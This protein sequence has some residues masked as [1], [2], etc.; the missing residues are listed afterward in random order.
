MRHAYSFLLRNLLLSLLA[1]SVLARSGSGS[2]SVRKTLDA[3]YYRL[4]EA[5]QQNEPAGSKQLLKVLEDIL[6]PG[7]L[8]TQMLSDVKANIAAGGDKGLKKTLSLRLRIQHL[9]VNGP[10]A[11]VVVE[12]TGI[13][14]RT[15]N[16]GLYGPVG[17]E[18]RIGGS[19]FFRDTWKNMG[20]QWKLTK[21]ED[22]KGT[23]LV[24]GKVW[25]PRQEPHKQ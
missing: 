25:K 3:A 24:D 16:E 23:L 8:R 13:A 12:Q 11:V 1:V 17:K 9:K 20:G 21:T 7:E 6:A 5:M 18:H 2:P 15:D 14:I 22:L 19:A 4:N 10:T